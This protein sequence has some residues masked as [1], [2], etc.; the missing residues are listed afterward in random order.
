[1]NVIAGC[2]GC[3]GLVYLDSQPFLFCQN[4]QYSVITETNVITTVTGVTIMVMNL[5]PVEDQAVI[6]TYQ[7]F[8]K[9]FLMLNTDKCFILSIL[10]A[11][12]FN[13]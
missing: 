13:M 9:A 2:R 3:G 10:I 12:A 4:L 7:S 6:G 5:T 11:I 1:M 8:V